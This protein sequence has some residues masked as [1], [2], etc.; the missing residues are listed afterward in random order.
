MRTIIQDVRLFDGN[1]GPAQDGMT[2]VLDGERIAWTGRREDAPSGDGERIDGRGKTLLPGLIDCHAHLMMGGRGEAEVD[3]TRADVRAV[4]RGVAN[5]RRCLETGV[6]AVRDLGWRTASVVDLALAVQAGEIDGP[7]IVAAARFIGPVGGYVEGMARE[8]ATPD[9]ARRWAEEQVRDGARVLKAI[10]SPVPPRAGGRPVADSFGVDALRAVADVAHAHGL[11]MTAHAHGLAGARDAVLAGADC[12][13][14]GYRLDTATVALMAERGTWLVPTMVAMEAAQAPNWAPGRPDE[15]A[16]RARERWEAAVA[17]V[18]T[19]H[20]AGIRL[21]TGTDSF[22]VV[23][24]ES[25]R[26]EVL[27]LVEDGGLEPAQALHA[28]TGAAAALL[29]IDDHTGGVR[30][31]MVADLLLVGGDPV[32]DPACLSRV[33]A[34][35]RRGRRVTAPSPGPPSPALRAAPRGRGALG[36]RSS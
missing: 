3:A 30:P 13:E 27:L 23:P 31:G 11:K 14:H 36:N 33:E 10:A 21:A 8:A 16:R 7:E 15:A 1:G 2:V 19:A 32:S 26:R 9:E 5:A 18:R 6:T 35:W 12:I 24:I 20:Q 4:L 34:V 22:A 25:L 17:A 29:G 28:A